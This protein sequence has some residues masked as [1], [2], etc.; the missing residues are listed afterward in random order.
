MFK[1]LL[2]LL[3]LILAIVISIIYLLVIVLEHLFGVDL[4]NRYKLVKS[5]AKIICLVLG[6]KIY[7]NNNAI[8]KGVLI[9]PNHR[10]WIDIPLIFSINP[11]TIIAKKEISSWPIIGWGFNAIDAILVDR[12][13]LGSLIKTFKEIENK[14][15]QN[16]TVILFPEGTICEGPETGRFKNGA[17]KAA[18]EHKIKIV[19]IAFEFKDRNAVWAGNETLITHFFK[20][21]GSWKTE[22]TVKIG[23]PI[24]SDDEQWLINQTKNWLDK[25]I[26]A[27]RHNF[28]NLPGKEWKKAI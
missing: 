6:I 13:K 27:M 17:F 19:P 5:W 3:R 15:L 7:K 28:D 10:S 1:F 23:E 18:A 8:P 26:L 14:I 22:I 21:M 2:A 20:C 4:K 25:E 9:L 11:A 24:Q 12:S 16:K